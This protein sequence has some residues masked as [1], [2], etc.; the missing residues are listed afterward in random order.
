MRYAEKKIICCL[1]ADKKPDY[2]SNLYWF[3]LLWTYCW[4]KN[5]TSC[6]ASCM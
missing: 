4:A 5:R 6:T 3:D 2:R 1:K